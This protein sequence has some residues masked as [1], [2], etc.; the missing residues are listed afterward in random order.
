MY[1]KEVPRFN[2]ENFPTW[3]N[4]MKLHL[5]RLGDTALTSMENGFT[6]ITDALIAQ[7]PK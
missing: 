5:A 6:M 1:K 4:L 2:K 3:Q 7:K